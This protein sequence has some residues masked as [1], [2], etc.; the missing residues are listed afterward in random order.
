MIHMII[1]KNHDFCAGELSVLWSEVIATAAPLA[2]KEISQRYR[3]IFV[4]I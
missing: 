3:M 1:G 2:K 4:M